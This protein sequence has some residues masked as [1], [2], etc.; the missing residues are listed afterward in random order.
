MI[1]NELGAGVLLA[2][3]ISVTARGQD[4]PPFPYGVCAH[5]ARGDEYGQLVEEL[6]LIKAAGIRWVR[7]DFTWGHFEPRDGEFRFERYDE[8]VKACLE[9]GID[10]LP[11]LCYDS[12][13][14]GYAH[15]NLPAWE[16]YVRRVTERYGDRLRYW[17]VWNEPNI[18]FWKPKPDPKQYAELLKLTHKTIKAVN[19]KLQ[20][21][22]GGTAGIPLDFIRNTLEL[23]AAK[24][25]D[26]MA[27]HPYSYPSTAERS[28]RLDQLAELKVLLKK[29]AATDRIWVTE[30]GW[31]THVDAGAEE[32]F[33]LWES[34]IT[35]AGAKQFPGNARLRVAVLND[36]E[37]RPAGRL[38]AGT[39]ARFKQVKDW[40]CRTVSLHDL[41]G[42]TPRNTDV[43]VGLFGECFPKP[44]FTEM[45]RFVRDGGM[46]V[47][48]G[49]VPLFYGSD[50]KDGK[51]QL[52]AGG[53]TDGNR[54]QLRIGWEAHWT[55]KGLPEEA[56]QIR[57]VDGVAG[58]AMPGKPTQ[59][60]RWFNDSALKKGDRFVP[61]LAAFSGEK[62]VGHPS[63]LYLLRS[64]MKGAVLVNCL[65]VPNTRGVDDATQAG[66]LSRA[67]L[68]YLAHGVEV[69]F[70]YEFRDGGA[71]VDYN[72][73]N[74]GMIEFGLKPKPAYHAMKALTKLLG[75]GP[76]FDGPPSEL[77]PGISCLRVTATN[78]R[79]FDIY[80]SLRGE[81]L[82]PVSADDAGRILDHLGRPLQ[83]GESKGVRCIK[84]GDAP[85][86]IQR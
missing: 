21:M 29:H 38:A 30:T 39:A 14:A 22:Y 63:A 65:P 26:V 56:A 57:A 73:H 70:W 67:Y 82:L 81:L 47:H 52:R 77:R 86:F 46:L 17:E 48:F 80:W 33:E 8:V 74:F 43:L 4:A 9:R 34:L 59:T 45:V 55:Q 83:C 84:V 64:D 10:V 16:R 44:Q 27:V 7:A 3:L 25:F 66:R 13:W 15:A 31:P 41:A 53:G 78:N 28:E 6:D 58:L 35:A 24:H 69:F 79:L 62:F 20:V 32:Q 40:D 37:Y 75:A 50:V 5:L 60:T 71:N 54:R 42:V 12:P 11:I 19:P 36:L 2:L 23:G 51:W 49:G 72:E 1:Q 61:L 76:S 18:H 85:V 68:T